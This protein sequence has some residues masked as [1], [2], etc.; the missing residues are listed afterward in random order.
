MRNIDVLRTLAN[1]GNT[2]TI[3]DATRET[4]LE[5]EALK[6]MLFRMEKYGWIERIEK[7]KYLIIPGLESK[8]IYRLQGLS[9]SL[10][11][12]YMDRLVAQARAQ[13]AKA[14]V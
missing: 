12:W 7:G 13:K 3:N 6:K 5:I 8:L 10:L 14:G 2:F 1:K 9:G 4:R 11:Y